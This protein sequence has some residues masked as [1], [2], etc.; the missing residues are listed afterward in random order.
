MLGTGDRGLSGSPLAVLGAENLTSLASGSHHVC[1]L[2]TN[3]AAYCWG[4]DLYGQ[5]GIGGPSPDVCRTDANFVWRCAKSAVPVT[6]GRSFVS[7]VAGWSHT[8]GLAADGRAYC[9][10]EYVLAGSYGSTPTSVSSDLAFVS[11]SDGASASHTCGVTADHVAYCWGNNDFG[12]L[13]D[14]GTTSTLGAVRVSGGLA[15][16]SITTGAG[17]TC[18]I[19]TAGEVYCWG[20]NRMGQ[21]G[22]GATS[23]GSARP[24]R[25][26]GL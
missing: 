21:L 24:L 7:L 20:D 6:G 26:P 9:W 17:H 5:L 11:L 2:T 16:S 23:S 14:G 13:G 22:V 25:V 4:L 1:G 18:G 3:G 19:T 12:Q 8:C 10:G 15:F